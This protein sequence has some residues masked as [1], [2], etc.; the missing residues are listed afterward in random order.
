MSAIRLLP[1]T[2]INQIA[3][4]EVVERPASVVKELLE[5]SLDAGA[6]SIQFAL[7]QGGVKLIRV[8]DDGVGIE[9]DDLPRALARH[10]T[11]KIAS[12]DD[13]ERVASMGF[14]G[15]ALA[16]I[17]GVARVTITSRHGPAPHAFRIDGHSHDI[18]PAALSAGTVVEAADLYF[19]T[20]ARRK[21]LRTEATEYARCAEV[22]R[23][24]ALAHP[25]TAFCLQH[26]GR[27]NLRFA[28]ATIDARIADVLGSEFNAAALALDVPAGPLRLH[29]RL[30]PA[31]ESRASREAQYFY[32]NGRYVRD[33]LL[34]HAVAE[35]YR[36]LLHGNRHPGF[37][38]FLEIDPLRVDVNVH[39][40][41]TELRFRDARAIHQF[42]FHA[43]ARALAAPLRTGPAASSGDLPASPPQR[44]DWGRQDNLSVQ[45][46]VA[47]YLNFV[48]SSGGSAA[49]PPA[50]LA[51]PTLASTHDGDSPLGYALAQLLGI[52]VLAQNADGLV[53]VDMHAAHERVLY[54]RLKNEVDQRQPVVQQL[55]IPAIVVASERDMATCAEHAETLQRLGFDVA[56]AGPEQLALRAV[57]AMLANA[58]LGALLHAL[59]VDLAE[60]PASDVITARRNELLA[61][62]AC[63]GA[64]RARRNLSLPEMNALL[65]D[66]EATERAGQCNHGR[67]TWAQL[68]LAELDRLFLRGR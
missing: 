23:R 46:A 8:A 56:P 15:E 7:E 58:D 14:R 12:L 39:P 31:T 26:N 1:E 13:L 59:L 38:L 18:V 47:P 34:G 55:L 63:H 2:L 67:P 32:V 28:T 30:L 11:S 64:V 54:E 68:P 16:A 10:A 29:G 51:T 33:K 25:T 43:V 65:R 6:P 24:V 66:I 40:A 35:A 44:P 36:D 62:M 42:V 60:F 9:A 37:V 5:N 57:P 52:Y 3:A 45:Q 21:F 50:P 41:K 49:L 4:G 19:N 53:L 20:P 48:S 27:A 22:L 61:T 17:A